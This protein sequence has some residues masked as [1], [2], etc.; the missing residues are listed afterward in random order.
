VRPFQNM[1]VND[2]WRRLDKAFDEENPTPE[3]IR[4]L[5]ARMVDYFQSCHQHRLHGLVHDRTDTARHVITAAT[6]M[7]LVAAGVFP[8]VLAGI[9][10]GGSGIAACVTGREAYK[11]NKEVQMAVH[12]LQHELPDL[13]N[14]MDAQERVLTDREALPFPVGDIEL[15]EVVISQ[16]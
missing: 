8:L 4:S 6:V 11:T 15:D 10:A 2:E 5:R 1:T 12:I 9:V 3:Q 14:E 16:S 7:T 13:L